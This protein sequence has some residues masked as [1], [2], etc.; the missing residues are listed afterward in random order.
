MAL[1]MV[2]LKDPLSDE[3]R[4]HIS[5]SLSSEGMHEL[6]RYT[7]LIRSPIS[8]TEYVRALFGLS[9]KSE[10]PRVGVAFRLNGSYS[11]Y[12][13]DALWDWLAAA[14]EEYG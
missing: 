8:D 5:G 1:F 10:S 12:H 11:G 7:F 3:A 14:R 4:E 13:H 9:E 2:V 6:S